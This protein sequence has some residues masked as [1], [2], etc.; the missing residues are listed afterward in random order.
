MVVNGNDIPR[1]E[2]FP[3][4]R[5]RVDPGSLSSTVSLREMHICVNLKPPANH[6][7]IHIKET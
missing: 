2:R 4:L 6:A 7:L 1:K 5:D 3:E